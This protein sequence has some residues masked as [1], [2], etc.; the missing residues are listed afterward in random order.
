[1][2]IEMYIVY[3]MASDL[4]E[5]SYIGYTKVEGCPSRS[6]GGCIPVKKVFRNIYQARDCCIYPLHIV[7]TEDEAK[8]NCDDETK[9]R[10]DK[11]YET[12]R[13]SPVDESHF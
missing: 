7:K 9:M 10:K 5:Q 12:I 11:P 1:V 6:L 2:L 3:R 13:V 8:K 4:L